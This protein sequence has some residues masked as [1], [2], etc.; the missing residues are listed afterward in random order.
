MTKNEVEHMSTTSS[1]FPLS[2]RRAV[3]TGAAQGLGRAFAVALAD[4]GASVAVCDLSDAVLELDGLGMHAVVADVSNPDAVRTFI[5]GA[6]TALGGI[7]LLVNNA[8]R[9]RITDAVRDSWEQALEDFEVVAGTNYRGAFLVGRATIPHIVTAGGGDIVNITTDHIHTC[10]YPEALD[11]ADAP[12]CPWAGSPRPALGG[13]KFDVYDSSKWAIKGLTNV[14]ARAL[15]PH[16]IRV[17]SL[18]MGATDTHMYRNHLGDRPPPPGVMR[19]EQTAGVL[20]ELLA[21]GPGGRTS[22]CI[23][24]WV[25]HRCELPPPGVDAQLAAP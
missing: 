6:A 17:N 21:E 16:H 24:L 13:P 11:H 3:V 22:D 19:P 2:G 14:W 25:G 15:R 1:H 23:Q 7:D 9:V 5:D 10:G 4:A 18:G 20:L 8:G 12:E